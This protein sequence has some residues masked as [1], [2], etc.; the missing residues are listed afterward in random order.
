[1]NNI[2][3]IHTPLILTYLLVRCYRRTGAIN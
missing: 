3:Y 1:V 2:L